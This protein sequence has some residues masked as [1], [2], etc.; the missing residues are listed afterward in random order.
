MIKKTS[1]GTLD[2]SSE[3]AWLVS[4]LESQYKVDILN[5][6]DNDLEQVAEKIT[7]FSGTK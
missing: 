4:D 3:F 1:R 5:R 7:Y 6:P 2:H